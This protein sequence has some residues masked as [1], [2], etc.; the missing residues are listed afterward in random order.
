MNY[1]GCGTGTVLFDGDATRPRVIDCRGCGWAHQLPLPSAE[2]LEQFYRD[3]FY[4]E[5]R[6]NYAR[7]VWEDIDW[8][9]SFY[10]YVFSRYYHHTDLRNS[11]DSPP[12]SHFT[13][14]RVA[15]FGTALSVLDFGSGPGILVAYCE[16]RGWLITAVDPSPEAVVRERDHSP[17]DLV[18]CHLVLEHLLDPL[19]TLCGFRK[20]M[21]QGSMLAVTVPNDFNPLQMQIGGYHW[22]HPEHINYF[23]PSS[24]RSLIEQAGFQVLEVYGTFPMELFIMLGDDYRGNEKIGRQC[25]HRRCEIERD[26]TMARWRVYRRLIERGIGREILV[27]ATIH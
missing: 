9:Y 2:E 17:F 11:C 16:G 24:I 25:H 4:Q 3:Q 27:L 22:V 14:S 19:E 12:T 15:S 23:N 13:P 21:R 8:W 7:E 6:P 26:A 1:V 20:V 18:N 5:A 10:D